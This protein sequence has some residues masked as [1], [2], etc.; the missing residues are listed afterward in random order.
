[1]GQ[2]WVALGQLIVDLE[3]FGQQTDH[4]PAGQVAQ[5]AH[6]RHL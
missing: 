1:L 2:H 6:A 3:R 5:D 4:A